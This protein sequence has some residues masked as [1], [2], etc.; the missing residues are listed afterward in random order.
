DG[1]RTFTSQPLD[2][3]PHYL[4]PQ[5]SQRFRPPYLHL[6]W[7]IDVHALFEYAQEHQTL[8]PDYI[9]TFFNLSF[10]GRNVH[11]SFN[12]FLSYLLPTLG[13]PGHPP[14]NLRF[15]LF[16]D[17]NCLEQGPRFGLSVG[18]NYTGT[19]PTKLLEKLN[20]FFARGVAP[21]W[22]LDTQNYRW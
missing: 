16:Y 21:R 18:T 20:D 12:T 1:N 14:C 17:G 4:L 5:H 7:F 2:I 3:L 11:N 8:S 15:K 19:V 13:F 6:G 9:D 10:D 22:F